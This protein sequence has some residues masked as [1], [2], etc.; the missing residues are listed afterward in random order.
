M[1]SQEALT[2][3]NQLAQGPAG[4]EEEDHIAADH[5]LCQLLDS[6]GY[7]EVVEAYDKIAKWY[8]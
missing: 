4:G 6:L 1:T 3:L 8:A 5:I 7:H 2:L